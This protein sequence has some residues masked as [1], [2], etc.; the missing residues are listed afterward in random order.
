MGLRKLIDF[1]IKNKIKQATHVWGTSLSLIA[2]ANLSLLSKNINYLEYPSVKF[3]ISDDIVEE[4]IKIINGKY[5]PN[6]Y[7]GFGIKITDEIKERY[8]LTK[9][10]GYRI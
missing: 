2:N 1:S 6:T 4:K 5:I 3:K 8:S 7:P 10:S 9:N